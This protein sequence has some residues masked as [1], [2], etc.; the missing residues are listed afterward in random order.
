VEEKAV[1]GV[2]KLTNGVVNLCRSRHAGITE[3]EVKNVLGS[4]LRGAN[5]AV[6]ENFSYNRALTAKRKCFLIDSHIFVPYFLQKGEF[7]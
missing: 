2:Q 7:A 1:F 5:F 3:A 4:D 6:F